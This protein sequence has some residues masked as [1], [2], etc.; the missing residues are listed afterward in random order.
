MHASG[1]GKALLAEMDQNELEQILSTT[2]LERFTDFTI[3]DP[4]ALALDLER[5]RRRGF[6]I[7]DQEKNLGDPDLTLQR[8]I[9]TYND[10]IYA[11]NADSNPADFSLV[12]IDGGSNRSFLL[13]TIT[14]SCSS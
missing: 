8:S 11:L 5:I 1:I 13:G 3:T 6:A 12:K 14:R 2:P 4:G 9:V 7:D 10:I